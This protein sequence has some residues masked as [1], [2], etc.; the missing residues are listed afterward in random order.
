MNLN[1]E[2]WNWVRLGEVFQIERGGSPRPID[3]YFTN[4]PDGLNWIKIGDATET[5]KYIYATKQ[6]IKPEGARHSRMVYPG[7]FIL[8]NSMS[9]GR[10]YIMQTTGCIHDGWLLLRDLTNKINKDYLYYTLGSDLVN[11]QFLSFAAGTTVKNLNIEVVK[12]V[13]IPL[14]PPEEQEKIAT[15]FKSVEKV[16]EQWDTQTKILKELRESLIKDLTREK[17][18]FGNLLEDCKLT[19]CKIGDIAIEIND[20]IENPSKSGLNIFIGLEDFGTGELFIQRH[21]STEKLVSTMKLC[22]EG[23]VLFARRNAYLRR[24]S[25][26]LWDAVCSGDVIVMRVKG[27]LIRPEFMTVLMNTPD[28]WN[29]AISNAAG[30]MSKR[31]KWRDLANYTFELP[32]IS[33]QD[34]ILVVI[35]K[36]ENQLILLRFQAEK[37]HELKQNILNEI[38]D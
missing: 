18:T 22:K 31:V 36:I 13:E 15:L 25:S 24:A 1:K 2:M 11:R 23:D 5:T 19:V 3:D 7:D 33:I 38:L 29:F 21:S 35:N 16:V 6:K 32:D 12:K 4:Q 27:N 14:P 9:F 30:T 10:P 28:F 20:R 37:L 17:P 26:T 8:S 34:K